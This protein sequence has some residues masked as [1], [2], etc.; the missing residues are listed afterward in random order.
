MAEPMCLARLQLDL[1]PMSPDLTDAAW[2]AVGLPVD[3]ATVHI[4]HRSQAIR[5]RPVQMDI[6]SSPDVR[7]H[8]QTPLGSTAIL[9]LPHTLTEPDLPEPPLALPVEVRRISRLCPLAG[10]QP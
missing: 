2:P 9:R 1:K 4:M 7:S 3:D 10:S 8:G 5:C 6:G